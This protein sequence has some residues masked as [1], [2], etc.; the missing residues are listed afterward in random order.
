[1]DDLRL[2]ANAAENPGSLPHNKVT[3]VEK[4]K[5]GTK[6]QAVIQIPFSRVVEN[7]DNLFGPK[8]STQK[9]KVDQ[10]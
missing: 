10:E 4:N 5:A 8:G 1:M 6:K 2:S 7:E 3:R 9:G